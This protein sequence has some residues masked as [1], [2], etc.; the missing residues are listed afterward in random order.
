MPGEVTALEL[1]MPLPAIATFAL[2]W[3]LAMLGGLLV[4]N[5]K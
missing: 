3:F 5:V 4:V 1:Y 2:G